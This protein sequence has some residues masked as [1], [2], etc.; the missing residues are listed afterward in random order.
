MET[1]LLRE[2][3]DELRKVNRRL[4]LIEN[5]VIE[6]KVLVKSVDNNTDPNATG[7]QDVIATAQA[8]SDDVRRIANGQ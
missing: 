6:T 5:E 1:A 3:V 4:T 2:I 7:V 8:I